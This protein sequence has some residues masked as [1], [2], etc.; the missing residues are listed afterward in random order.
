[1][2]IGNDKSLSLGIAQKV[3]IFPKFPPLLSPTKPTKKSAFERL[4]G[5][6]AIASGHKF[7]NDSLIIPSSV[8]AFSG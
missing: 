6:Q 4:F 5:G 1:M 3:L 2:F 7:E 8:V